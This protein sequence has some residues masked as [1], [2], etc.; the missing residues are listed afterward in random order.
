MYTII[1]RRMLRFR[2]GQ[3][4]PRPGVAITGN[5]GNTAG[6]RLSQGIGK[7]FMMQGRIKAWAWAI[8]AICGFFE[9]REWI[10]SAKPVC[11]PDFADRAIRWP[12]PENNQLGLRYPRLDS[13]KGPDQMPLPFL[14][15]HPAHCD[16]R[17]VVKIA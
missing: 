4:F 6:H 16:Q 10:E 9:T 17:R 1:N 8:S 15:I 7:S 13:R 14:R 3:D 11:R 5:D 2:R 12:L